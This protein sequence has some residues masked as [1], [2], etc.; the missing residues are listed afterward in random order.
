MPERLGDGPIE[1]EYLAKMEH[2]ARAL[3][4][5]FNGTAKGPDRQTGFVLMVYRFGDEPGRRCNY[6]SNGANRRDVVTLM[7]EMI[8]R[9][10]GQPEIKGR[11]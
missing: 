11:A 1:A 3:D 8:A 5:F 7:R 6:I 10:E 2:V 4:E 9:F